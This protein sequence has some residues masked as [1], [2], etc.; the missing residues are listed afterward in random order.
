VRISLRTE[1]ILKKMGGVFLVIAG[2]KM[3]TFS[4]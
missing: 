3:A 4:Q 2:I 1:A